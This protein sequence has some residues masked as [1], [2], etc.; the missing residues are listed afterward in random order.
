MFYVIQGGYD[1]AES[2]SSWECEHCGKVNDH[3]KFCSKCGHPK[4]KDV[5]ICHQ[6][7][8]TD[9]KGKFCSKCGQRRM[10]IVWT[11]QTCGKTDNKGKFCSKCGQDRMLQ[12]PTR[13]VE[14]HNTEQYGTGR[15]NNTVPR[16]VPSAAKPLSKRSKGIIAVIIFI[17]IAYF[18][19]G[20]VVEK[21]YD[22]KCDEFISMSADI[23]KAIDSI[24]DLNGDSGS[25]ESKKVAERFESY[26]AQLGKL[27]DSLAEMKPPE[28]MKDKHEPFLKFI[29]N[30]QAVMTQI[31]E[32]LKYDVRTYDR[33]TQQEYGKVYQKYRLAENGLN[34]SGSGIKIKDKDLN[35]LIN[36]GKAELT[37]QAYI[38]KKIKLDSKYF[39]EKNKEYQ[40]RKK[41]SNEEA[42]Q[43]NEVVFLTDNVQKNGKDLLIHGSF[44]N[45]TADTVVGIKEMLVDVTLNDFDNEIDAIKDFAYDD[46]KFNS[47]LLAPHSTSW[48]LTLRIADK[49]P[50]DSFN[51][52]DV[53][54]HKIHWS[55]R[56]TIKR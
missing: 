51:N 34:S 16:A 54:V 40:A 28:T 21:L 55:V 22:S 2:S 46:S 32:V 30:E 43:K 53:H 8:K 24:D 33:T 19:Y 12:H 4:P 25:E 20:T 27:H 13:T 31:S 3:G 44:Y 1:M 6:C 45:G 9:N 48:P 23:A 47:L 50:E 41:A 52:F 5:W 56:K 29:E 38:E 18:G 15:V 42:K 11:C 49:A 36:Y 7:G 17:V 26:A 37:L 10:D 39:A 35:T 14:N